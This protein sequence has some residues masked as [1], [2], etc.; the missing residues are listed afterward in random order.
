MNS[1]ERGVEGQEAPVLG[2]EVAGA[3]A[4]RAEVGLIAMWCSPLRH[5]STMM[6]ATTNK[7]KH[8]TAQGNQMKSIHNY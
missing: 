8:A 2:D 7:D 1:R 6:H 3:V 4:W 5:P